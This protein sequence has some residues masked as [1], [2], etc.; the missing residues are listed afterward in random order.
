MHILRTGFTAIK[1]GRHLDHGTVDLATTGPVGDRMFAL[2]D[3]ERRAV[4]RTVRNPALLAST[5]QWADGVLSVEI[6]GRRI[7]AVPEP[8]DVAL[9]LDYWGR[10]AAVEIVDGP[11]ASA[12]SAL[13]GIEVALARAL[14]PGE[15]VYG[16]PVTIVTTSGIRLLEKRAGHEIDAH[17]FRATFLVDTDGLDAAVE[18]SWAGEEIRVG[19][20]RL[21]VTGAID[22]CAVIDLDPR[23]GAS[24]TRLLQILAEYRLHGKAV[25]FG[26]YAEVVVPGCVGPGDPVAVAPALPDPALH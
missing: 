20:A 14:H 2:V 26:V 13:L 1:G 6:G 3:L 18:D 23:S 24:G 4:L 17:R 12:Y 5:A 15:L 8:S 9:N 16:A 10:P 25:D 7:E 21:R 19:P 22:R 11:W